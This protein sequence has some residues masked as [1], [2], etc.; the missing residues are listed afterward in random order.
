M[1]LTYDGHGVS[2]SQ[3]RLFGYP[4]SYK[5]KNITNIITEDLSDLDQLRE[6]ILSKGNE[7]FEMN[8]TKKLGGSTNFTYI[9]HILG[10]N[11][12]NY[13]N[14]TK[15]NRSSPQ[16]GLLLKTYQSDIFTNWINSEWINGENGIRLS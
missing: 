1:T 8:L 2:G 3:D 10:G 6:D 15:Y 14:A 11:N 5:I 13:E 4:T 9:Q 16:C 12:S 7:R